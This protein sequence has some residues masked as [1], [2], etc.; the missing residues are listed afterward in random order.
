[1][2]EKWDLPY[3]IGATDAERI[4]IRNYIKQG[5]SVPPIFGDPL[6]Q[7]GFGIQGFGNKDETQPADFDLLL[8]SNHAV[9]PSSQVSFSWQSSKDEESSIAYYEVYIDGEKRAEVTSPVYT[10]TVIEYGSH[11][12]YVVA[13]NGSGLRKNSV[14]TFQFTVSPLAVSM[15]E[16]NSEVA[17][18]PNPTTGLCFLK[19]NI[20][21]G[22][23]RIK[24]TDI[25]GKIILEINSASSVNQIDISGY[26]SG[27]Y[28]LSVEN[29]KYQVRK[30]IKI[31][32]M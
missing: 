21:E 4:R 24:I 32:K 26:S 27:L 20:F 30:V 28:F 31:V 18:W 10:T 15:N 25:T 14:S 17:I 2:V 19:L 11:S 8:P 6:F 13:V 7:Y 29:E 22:N 9:L 5:L 23:N 16:L 12:W 3:D 1:M